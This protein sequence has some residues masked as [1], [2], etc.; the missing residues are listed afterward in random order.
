M[1]NTISTMP[2]RL[3]CDWPHLRSEIL[4]QWKKLD[5]A[6]IDRVGPSRHNIAML[7]EQKYGIACIQAENYLANVE[8]CMPR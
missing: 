5:R 4:Q 3:Q 8:R 1:Q 2:D 6:E 7:I